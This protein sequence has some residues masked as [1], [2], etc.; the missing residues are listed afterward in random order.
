MKWLSAPQI[1]LQCS[2]HAAEP[3]IKLAGNPY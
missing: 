1:A 3:E 2:A